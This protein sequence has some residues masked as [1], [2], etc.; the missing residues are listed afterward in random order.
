MDGTTLDTRYIDAVLISL[1][2]EVSSAALAPFALYETEHGT[3]LLYPM[4][5]SVIICL[6]C[7]NLDESTHNRITVQT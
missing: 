4:I 5:F 6:V 1:Q 7:L 2:E 3:S